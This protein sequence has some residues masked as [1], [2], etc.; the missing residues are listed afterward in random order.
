[1]WFSDYENVRFTYVYLK[2][3]HKADNIVRFTVWVSRRRNIN[4][5][6]HPT[7]LYMVLEVM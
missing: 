2:L 5:E 1:M 6:N 7:N 4:F 3:L